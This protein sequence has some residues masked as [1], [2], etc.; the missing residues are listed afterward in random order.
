M[1]KSIIKVSSPKNRKQRWQ[2]HIEPCVGGGCR[3]AAI[4]SKRP[5]IGGGRLDL[6]RRSMGDMRPQERSTCKRVLNTL[7]RMVARWEGC[8]W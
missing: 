8:R 5:G 6:M 7:Q 3:D 2:R 1:I 4:G